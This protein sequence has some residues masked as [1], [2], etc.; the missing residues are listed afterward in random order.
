MQNLKYY[1]NF[2]AVLIFIIAAFL[3][4]FNVFPICYLIFRSFFNDS[5]FTLE[6]F[7]RI[8][9]YSLNWTALRNTLITAT[10]SMI[11]GVMIAFPLAWLVGRTDLYGKKFFRTLFVMTYMVPPYVGAMAWLRLLNPRVGTLNVFLKNLLSLPD[12]PFNIYTLGGLVWV[13]T[14]F[15]YPYAFITISR[16]MEKMDPSLEEASKISGASP[17]KTV[18]TVTFPIMLPSIVAAGLLVFISAASCYGIPSIIGAPGQID[19][20]TTRIIDYVYVGS[21]EGLTDATTLAV[22]LML[23]A[24]IVLYISTFICGKKQYITVSGKSTRPNIVELGKWRIPITILVSL[25]ALIVVIIPFATVA[26]T[27]FTKNLGKPLSLSN[28]TTRYWN[29]LLTRKTI[30]DS[31][32]NSLISASLAATF[33]IIISCVM[34][35]LLTRTKARG[36][37]I[38]DFLI[39]LGSGTPSVVIALALI[40]TMSGRF[41]INIYNTLSIMI[42]AYMIKYLLMGMRTIVSAMNQIHPSLEEAALISGAKWQRSFR[43]VVLPLIAPSV[44]AGWFLIFMPSFY[45]L[46]MSTLLYSTDTKTIGYELFTYQTYHSQ[47]TA[48]AIATGILVLVI[49]VNWILN[50]L[51]KGEFS[52]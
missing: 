31:A 6:A 22:S 10:L 48:S 52:I 19:T 2:K 36:R 23:I 4:L 20:V 42:I 12:N 51:T 9:T 24:N 46:T 43:D 7:K 3:L 11:F 45:E 18:L 37:Q 35:W 50:K 26:I 49:V 39:T 40:M 34:A 1:F 17:L 27:S 21:A 15:Y 16:A 8:Y 14:T 33:G 25:F 32:M 47:Q 41:G 5:G 13:L 29:I 30:F 44:V 38:P 28:F